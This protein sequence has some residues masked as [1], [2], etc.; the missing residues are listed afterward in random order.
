MRRVLACLFLL[1]APAA[2]AQPAPPPSPHAHQAATFTLSG[3]G[4]A[5]AAPDMAVLTSGVVSQ[6]ET[7]RG[8]LDANN[9]AMEKLVA[10][11]RAAGIESR[12]I[13]TS[14]FS[15]QPRYI[16][17]QGGDTA[18]APKITG[19][20]VRNAVTAKVR[21]LDN[22]GAILDKAVTEGSNQ[23]DALAF[24]ISDKAALLDEARRKAF[25]DARGKA[26]KFADAAGVKLGRLRELSDENVN[27]PPP[28]PMMM[29]AE[30][31][32]SAD[33][34]V[35]RGEQEIEVNVRTVWEIA[36]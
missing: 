25:E 13:Q 18:Q 22:L 21:D 11:L 4:I 27:A 32:K 7:A 8:A 5:S 10:A 24:D 33:V 28:R 35:E 23:V 30:M 9:A 14:G 17:P 16:Y 20:E 29:R 1:A 26:Q 12:D 2:L 6:D 15:V 31:A 3:Q 34:P 19:Y 36:P